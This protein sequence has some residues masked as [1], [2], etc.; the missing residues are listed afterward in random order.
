MGSEAHRHALLDQFGE[1]L[2]EKGDDEQTDM[3]TINIGIGS[4]DHLV[5]AQRFQSILD[6]ESGLKEVEL[7]ILIND[8][9]R[10]SKRVEGFPA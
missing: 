2:K 7:L 8:L 5:V 10:Q 9:L 3:H 4:N 6:I 1:E